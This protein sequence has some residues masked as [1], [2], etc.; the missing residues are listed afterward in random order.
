VRFNKIREGLQEAMYNNE[1]MAIAF[2]DDAFVF[3]INAG[4][5]HL[6]LARQVIQI[7]GSVFLGSLTKE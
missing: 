3:K 7:E 6:E 5:Q 2:R 4:V 1:E